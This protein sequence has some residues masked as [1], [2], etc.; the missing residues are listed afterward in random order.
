MEQHDKSVAVIKSSVPLVNGEEPE[1]KSLNCLSC[2]LK[3]IDDREAALI[4]MICVVHFL[5][6]AITGIPSTLLINQRLA[7]DA[8]DPNSH[9]A[10]V[11]ATCSFV[12]S[13]VSF[14][15]ARYTSG[16]GDY[17]GRKPMMVMSSL[18]FVFSRV[19]YLRAQSAAGFYFAAIL[20]G[21]FDCYYFTALA[22]ICD[23]FPDKARRSKRVGLFTG[24][25]GGFAFI[26]GV[27]LGAVLATA[28]RPAFP[29]LVSIVTATAALVVVILV[30]VDDRGGI[31][32][33][34][35]EHTFMG[36]RHFPQDW[37]R[38][39][40][41]H[42]AVSPGG[43]RLIQQ[44]NHPYDWLVNFLMHCC[45]NILYLCLLQFC[46]AVFDWSAI[47]ASGAVLLIGVCLGIE[48]PT[49]LH[50]YTSVSVA[51]YAMISF[52]IGFIL[53]AISGTGMDD[54]P[55]VG[56][57][58][59]LCVACGVCFVPALQTNILSQYP[60]DVQGTISGLLGQQ[61]DS[62]L[63]P[64]YIM[65]LGFTLSLDRKGDIYWPGSTFAAVRDVLWYW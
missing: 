4:I 17:V 9:S 18:V 32:D 21:S 29:L 48:S 31:K 64:A 27:P 14:I 38:Y 33:T 40:V 13:F 7:G 30:P 51:F 60:R 45:T 47:A 36:G 35:N 53:F 49:C 41:D 58:A 37:W 46:L 20:G 54:G 52:S 59:V 1:R 8:E 12:H 16:L 50:R 57:A 26:I 43:F 62:S 63:L 11:A 55:K 65:S 28:V 19:L 22:W 56:I 23:I 25:L 61:N 24:L 15:M 44:A 42:F 34:N 6:V 39:A 3:S 10:F 2:L 5:S